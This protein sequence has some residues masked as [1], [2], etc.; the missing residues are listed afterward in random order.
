MF[1]VMF[2]TARLM[3]HQIPPPTGHQNVK[4]NPPELWSVDGVM[5]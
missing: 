3:D 4:L 1:A 2:L 5:R